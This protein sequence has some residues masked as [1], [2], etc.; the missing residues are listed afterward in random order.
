MNNR[1]PGF[2]AFL[3]SPY[4]DVYGPSN[5]IRMFTR[6]SNVLVISKGRAPRDTT[7]LFAETKIKMA[8]QAF[9]RALSSLNRFDAK[10]EKLI[11]SLSRRSSQRIR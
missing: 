1:L 10:T 3:S 6:Q 4:V 7:D 11:L 9:S 5:W 8:E 2:A